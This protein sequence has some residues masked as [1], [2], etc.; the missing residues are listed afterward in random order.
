MM[1]AS[2]EW[3]MERFNRALAEYER[4]SPKALPEI[5]NT[6]ALWIARQALWLTKKADRSVI[7][8]QLGE[9]VKVDRVTKRGTVVK[10]RA[11]SLTLGTRVNAP[12]AALI[13]NK[14]RGLISQAGL[15]GKEMARAIISLLG[16]RTRSIAFLKAGWVPAIKALLRYVPSAERGGRP[17]GGDAEVRQRGVAK[18]QGEPARESWTPLARIEN[19]ANAKGDHAGALVRY[20]EPA[21]QAAFEQEA[22]GMEAHVEK[23]FREQTA[24]AEALIAGH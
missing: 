22:A 8:E 21:L 4:V 17:D 3:V 12:L 20:G 6:K 23:K 15:Y 14:R 11:L 7:R 13:V 24:A 10:R 1:A 19:F 18:G 5:L 2:A 9:I 16:A